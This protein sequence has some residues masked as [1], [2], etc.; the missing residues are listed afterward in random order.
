MKINLNDHVLVAKI[1]ATKG[2]KGEVKIKS[3]TQDLES[4]FDYVLVDENNASYEITEA[5]F[6]GDILVAKLDGINNINQAE[7]LIN[8]DLFVLKSSLP[9]LEEDTFYHMDLINLDVV[10][11]ITKEKIGSV[12]ALY[13]FG[14]GDLLEIKKLD[15]SLEMINFNKNNVPEINLEKKYII[16]VMPSVIIA[17]ENKEIK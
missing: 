1:V 15:N 8:K 12:V 4:I 14:A 17:E 7:N 9:K 13:N 11:S 3:F 10:D 6:K 16:V 5:Y 2:L